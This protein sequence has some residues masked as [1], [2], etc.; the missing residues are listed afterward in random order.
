MDDQEYMVIVFFV[1]FVYNTVKINH[2]VIYE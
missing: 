1:V 2:F